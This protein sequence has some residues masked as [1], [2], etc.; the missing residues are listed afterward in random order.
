M[1]VKVPKLGIVAVFV[2]VF[3]IGWLTGHLGATNAQT[4]PVG[5]PDLKCFVLEKGVPPGTSVDIRTQFGDEQDVRLGHPSILCAPAAK[6]TT[7]SAGNVLEDPPGVDFNG[8]HY[9]C[10]AIGGRTQNVVVD[11][12]SPQMG[13]EQGLRVNSPKY[14]CV[15]AFKEV[16][17]GRDGGPPTDNPP[18]G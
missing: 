16:V 13:E 6:L 17:D 10:Y 11:L 14:F 15:P 5:I 18:G 2:A 4:S 9:K 3:A 8:P 1:R 12:F 7:D